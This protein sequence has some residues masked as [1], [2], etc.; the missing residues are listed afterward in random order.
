MKWNEKFKR[1]DRVRCI[2]EKF[3]I[4]TTG[5]VLGTWSEGMRGEEIGGWRVV[6]DDAKG[7]DSKN[8]SILA[9]AAAYVDIDSIEFE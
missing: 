2:D 8:E 6:F 3:G 5:F 7:A 9:L 4:G 1:G